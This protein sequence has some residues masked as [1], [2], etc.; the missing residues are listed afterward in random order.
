ML[1]HLEYSKIL[2][3]LEEIKANSLKIVL[4]KIEDA[5]SLV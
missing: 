2:I 4:F 1:R 3:R 5:E